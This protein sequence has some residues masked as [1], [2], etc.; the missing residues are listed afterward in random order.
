[1]HDLVAAR[2]KDVADVCRRHGVQRLEVFGSAA[3]ATDFDPDRSDIDV[4][5]E[6]TTRPMAWQPLIDLQNDLQNLFGRRVDVVER[7]AIEASRNPLRR[8]V[9][10]SEAELLYAA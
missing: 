10:L 5:V 7:S 8:R 4:L 1:M 3:R 6:F 9:V 2:T